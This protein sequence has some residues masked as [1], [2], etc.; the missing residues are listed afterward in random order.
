MISEYLKPLYTSND[1]IIHNTQDF[2]KFIQE[3]P[4]LDYH[5]E[6]V[7]YDVES[8]FTNVPI[9]DTIDY[10]LDQIYFNNKLL[11]ICSRLILKRLLFKLTPDSTFIFQSRYYKQTD[12][13]TMGGPLSVTFANIHLTKLENDVVRP[14]KPLFYKRYVDDIIN[15][16]SSNQPDVLFSA[17]NNYHPNIKFTIENNPTK[18]LDTSL[19]I[20]DQ[21]V[22]TSV[23]RK[24]NKVPIHWSSKVPKRYKRNMINGDLHRS[25]RIS[26]NFVAE[27]EYI[28]TKF[29]N[30]GFPT[31]F[32]NSVIN[33]FNNK[34]TANT[35]NDDDDDD[36][37]DDE[38]IIPSFLFAEPKKS[39]FVE[40][41]F[42]DSNE[43][44]VKRFLR[45]L[46]TFTNHEI[47]F[48]ITWRTKKVKQLFR[49]KDRN[50]HP[51]CKIYEG[52]CSCAKNYVGETKRNV[53]VRWREHENINKE[54]EPAKHLRDFPDHSFQWKVIL[55]AP[56][57]T[58]L[59]KN[60]EA[61]IIAQKKPSLNDQLDSN[62]LFLF[63]NG[64]T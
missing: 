19:C 26:M 53:E 12:G 33:Q 27:T 13:C 21:K 4:P 23:Y 43:S 32:T 30:A 15:R 18:F 42:C 55:N 60:I 14:T 29:R 46:K 39:V 9:A 31:R 11:K 24:A 38:M 34:L 63:R 61:S 64:I 25:H 58:R 62:R 28:K 36:D 54:S 51:A 37:D 56:L 57:N 22:S 17:I 40:I 5:E 10:I 16:R 6:Y 41:P 52:V 47:D 59:R 20:I 50:P 48:V 8:L 1:F 45:K 2:A 3:Q 49:L 44:L 35:H 7:S